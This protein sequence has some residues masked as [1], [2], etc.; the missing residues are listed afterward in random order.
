MAVTHD[1]LLALTVR[2]PTDYADYGGK[3]VR[4]E[5]GD[6]SYPDCS[7]GCRWAIWLAGDLG[8][9][10]C[11]CANPEGPRKGLLTFEH[12]AGHGCFAARRSLTRRGAMAEG[13]GG[14]E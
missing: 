11:V 4:W 8:D 13:D 14:R 9:D 10:W 7:H 12:Q 3:V 6:Q 2:L 1:D 5:R